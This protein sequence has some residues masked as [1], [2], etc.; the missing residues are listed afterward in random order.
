MVRIILQVVLPF[1]LPAACYFAYVYFL[2][3]KNPTAEIGI[4][5]PWFGLVAIG[6]IL[7]ML[8]LI[9]TAIFTGDE[10]GGRYVPPTEVDGKIIPGHSVYE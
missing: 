10:A 5:K 1:L 4:T 3:M 6:A 7:V 9:L 2:R 8:S